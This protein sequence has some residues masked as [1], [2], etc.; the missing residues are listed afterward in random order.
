MSPTFTPRPLSKPRLLRFA[1]SLFTGGDLD[2]DYILHLFIHI[3]AA[4]FRLGL[5]SWL[6]PL[7]RLTKSTQGAELTF[8]GTRMAT[9]SLR[10]VR[11]WMRLAHIIETATDVT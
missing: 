3:F 10:E 7:V 4:P 8:A 5:I 1:F 2:K 11:F 6:K 9:E